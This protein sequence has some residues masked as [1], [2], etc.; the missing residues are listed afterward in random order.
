MPFTRF[1]PLPPAPEAVST[2][3]LTWA[4]MEPTRRDAPRGRLQAGGSGSTPP[5]AATKG[6]TR[7]FP[8]TPGGSFVIN[9]PPAG[10]GAAPNNHA[11][12]TKFNPNA[13][14]PGTPT[15]PPSNPGS[16]VYSVY[17]GSQG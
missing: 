9:P 14:N 7:N 1:S 5:A 12:I 3:L 17:L 16:V 4:A 13:A 11:F 10:P 15:V 6:P 2:M 8:R